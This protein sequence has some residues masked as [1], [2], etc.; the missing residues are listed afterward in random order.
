LNAIIKEETMIDG[1]AKIIIVEDERIVGEDIKVRLHR[2]GYSVPSIV[3]SGEEAIEK[4]KTIRPDL[5]LNQQ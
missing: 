1:I 3:R 2:L 4:A 5:V